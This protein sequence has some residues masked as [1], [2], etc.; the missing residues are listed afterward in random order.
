MCCD[1]RAIEATGERQ[2]YSKVLLKAATGKELFICASTSFING[3]K[4]VSQRIKEISANKKKGILATVL[5][6]LLVTVLMV[7]SLTAGAQGKSHKIWA[8]S[9]IA[10]SSPY[11]ESF[12]NDKRANIL[13]LG[14]NN[15]LTDTI[16]LASIDENTNE[17]ELISIPRDT[18]YHR[19]GYDGSARNKISAAYMGDPINT[20]NAVSDILQGIPIHYY[21]VL[22]DEGV[23]NI[24][25]AI[26]GVPMNIPIDM[27]YTDPYDTPP[28]IIDIPAG[29]Q[30]LNGDKAVEFLRYRFG[31]EEGDLGRVKAHQQ[32]IKSAYN[33]CL[34]SDLS[35]VV[36]VILENI[37]SNLNLKNLKAFSAMATNISPENIKMET[38]PYNLQGEAPWYV[39]PEEA[40]IKKLV[41]DLYGDE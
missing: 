14:V 28:L 31:Y 26:G 32:F 20:A 15:N 5:V 10:E 1:Q 36:T 2:E 34:S 13:L 8:Q 11:Y 25:D 29:E 19:E 37:D 23:K 39:Y 24:V 18:Y 21:V 41:E 9:A 7:V 40:E 12:K 4:E 38:L 6:A 16:I 3:E 30:I 22:E 27:K 17:T 35:K 33:Q